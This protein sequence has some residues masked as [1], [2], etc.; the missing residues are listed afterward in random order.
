VTELRDQ[1]IDSVMRW[2]A[3]Q[4]DDLTVMVI[5]KK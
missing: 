1:I 3:T 2:Q 5:R 4:D